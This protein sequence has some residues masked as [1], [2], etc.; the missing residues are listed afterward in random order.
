M[1][2]VIDNPGKMPFRKIDVHAFF[3][4]PPVIIYSPPLLMNIGGSA[5]YDALMNGNVIVMS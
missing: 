1:A 4:L 2:P 3:S 5:L